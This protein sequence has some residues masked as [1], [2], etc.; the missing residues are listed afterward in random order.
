[1]VSSRTST[2][3]SVVGSGVGTDD[4][5]HWQSLL[6]TFIVDSASALGHPY[7]YLLR[8]NTKWSL[9][10]LSGLSPIHYSSLL[11]EC[12]LV[13]IRKNPADGS[14]QVMF[15]RTKWIAFLERYELH[16]ANGKGG[17]SEVTDGFIVHAAVFGDNQC[18][19]GTYK[20][21]KMA[22]LRVGKVRPGKCPPSNTAINSGDEPPRV[23]HAM[24]AVKM[25]FI[26]ATIRLLVVDEAKHED[27]FAVERWVLMSQ[28][29]VTVNTNS[30]KRKYGEDGLP[31]ETPTTP[32]TPSMKT[33]TKILPRLRR[34]T[35]SFHLRQNVILYLG[36]SRSSHSSILVYCSVEHV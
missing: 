11:L 24:R 3:S 13:R 2:F 31:N 33:P 19:P 5:S 27:V 9:C 30:T 21:T 1:M 14:R 16:G 25:K 15:D 7:F 20:A 12:Q 18:D 26:E 35:I 4:V 28:N 36:S 10:L 34:H 17:C 23:T 22:L 6:A 32:S 29:T 8:T